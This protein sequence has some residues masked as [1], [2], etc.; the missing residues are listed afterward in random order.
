MFSSKKSYDI[1]QRKKLRKF[2]EAFTFLRYC[3]PI[4]KNARLSKRDILLYAYMYIMNLLSNHIAIREKYITL[5]KELTLLN[6][7]DEF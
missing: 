7:L 4:D 3:L 6:N 5:M 1:V 2:D